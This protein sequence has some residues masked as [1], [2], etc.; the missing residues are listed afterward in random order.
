MV[1]KFT[2]F[3]NIDNCNDEELLRR[4]QTNHKDKGLFEEAKIIRKRR[5]AVA[6]QN[7]VQ[8]LSKVLSDFENTFFEYLHAYEEALSLKNG[9]KTQ[10]RRLRNKLKTVSIKQTVSELVFKNGTAGFK[11][12]ANAGLLEYSFENLVMIYKTEFPD[13][14][15]LKAEEKLNDVAE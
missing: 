9:K 7:E 5:I 12:L 14:V 3:E 4:L 11:L 15:V 6:A 10:A 8:S 2:S 13:T 1:T